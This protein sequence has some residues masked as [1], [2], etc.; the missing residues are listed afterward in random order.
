MTLLKFALLRNEEIDSDE[1]RAFFLGVMY[2]S[3][4]DVKSAKQVL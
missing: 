4:Q 2:N 1:V 3:F